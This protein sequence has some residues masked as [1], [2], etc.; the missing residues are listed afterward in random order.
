MTTYIIQLI[1]AV[2]GSIGFALLFRVRPKLMVSIG[3]GGFLTWGTYLLMFNL[4]EKIFLSSLIASIVCALYS[5]VL[6]KIQKTPATTILITSI[7]PLIPGS[8]LYYTM[9]NIV[10]GNADEA[11]KNAYVTLEFALSI[12][13]G[14]AAV[15]TF[16][17]MLLQ[18]KDSKR[19]EKGE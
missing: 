7:V 16:V 3:L 12:A 4:T 5:E 13:L 19:S 8:G 15:L 10:Q 6:A 1:T 2:L 17:S 11:I 14:I 18:K 9:I